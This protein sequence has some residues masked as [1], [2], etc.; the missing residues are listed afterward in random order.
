[1]AEKPDLS[2]I[3]LNYNTQDLL[4]QCLT[5]LI[6]NCKACFEQ[7]FLRK[8]KIENCEYEVIVVDNASSDGSPE[9]VK[10]EFPQAKLIANP[11]NWGFAKG[12]NVALRQAQGKYIL[13]LNSDTVV[14][15]ETLPRMIKFMEENPKVGVATCRVELADGS[16]DLACHRGFPTPWAS[17]TYFLGLEKLFPK[18]RIFGRYHLGF[19]PLDKI[20]EIDS[21]V[22][23]FYLLKKEVINQVG[24]LDEDYFMYGEDLDWSFRIKKA[25]W[26]LVYYPHVKIIHLKRKSGLQKEGKIADEVRELRRKTMTHFY[27]AMRLF[28]QKNYR[29]KYPFW[30]GR[31]VNLGINLKL[32]LSLRKI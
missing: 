6:E 3:I 10:K 1:M 18:S 14:E 22:G 8:V 31:L 2:I 15:K 4:R 28:Y 27:E 16:L 24:L 13:L 19:L 23:A 12:N 25:G 26:K 11:E 32:K 29:D 20:H 5:S 7:V 21:P 9:M 17:L 30:V